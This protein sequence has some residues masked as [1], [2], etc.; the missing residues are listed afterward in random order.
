MRILTAIL[1]GSLSVLAA[2]A[3]FAAEPENAWA[4]AGGPLAALGSFVPPPPGTEVVIPDSF[5]SYALFEDDFSH[6]GIFDE[7]RLGVLGFWQENAESVEGVYVTG[8]V[9]FDPF[10]DRFDNWFLDI[11]LRPRPHIG[12]TASPDGPDQLFAGLTW[13][14]PVW[15]MFF[16]EA[17][18]GGTVHNG[19]I[20][21]AQI[22]LGCH[23][24][25]RESFGVGADIGEHW[26]VMVGVDHSSHNG[27]CSDENDGLTHLGGYVG[28]RF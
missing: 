25:F 2:S 19:A 3:A 23:A 4:R 1:A 26:R 13:T 27:W 7:V 8:Q 10:F 5:N 11:L 22:S 14:V 15:R 12:G 20:Q 24:L 16:V 21:G 28:Y 9:L 18:F 6:G 17:S